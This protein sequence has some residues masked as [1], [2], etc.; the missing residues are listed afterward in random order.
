MV[1]G[2]IRRVTRHLRPGRDCAFDPLL[3]TANQLCSWFG[4]FGT[5]RSCPVDFSP[6]CT[7][8]VIKPPP[9]CRT[10]SSPSPKCVYVWLQPNDHPPPPP[11]PH[12]YFSDRRLLDGIVLKNAAAVSLFT[13]PTTLF[14]AG[15]PAMAKTSPATN[16]PCPTCRSGSMGT[17]EPDSW[18]INTQTLF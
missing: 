2:A 3:T 17:S 4:Y 13:S 11:N 10:A 8:H 15:A 12:Y 1:S 16:S 5:L 18:S 7:S 6:T 14:S 9:P